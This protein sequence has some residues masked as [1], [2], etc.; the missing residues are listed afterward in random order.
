MKE[1]LMNLVRDILDKVVKN[2]GN[3]W[4]TEYKIKEKDKEKK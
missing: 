1:L 3:Q 4:I 2:V